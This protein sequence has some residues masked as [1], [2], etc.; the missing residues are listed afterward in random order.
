MSVLDDHDHVYGEKLR[1]AAGAVSD[2]Q[3]VVA[4]A[5]QLLTLGIPCLYYGTEQGLAG[6][7]ETERRWLPGWGSH[8]RYLREA[9]FGPRFPRIQGRNGVPGLGDDR[10]DHDLPG[11]G[12]FGTA[13]A[14]CFD[15]D[16]PLY[17]R[18]AA[19]TLIRADFPVL[20]SGR[21]YLRPASV[22]GEPFAP[23]E[24]GELIG[25]S[26]IL[27]D[28]EA[29]CVVNPNGLAA[30]GADLL[31]DAQLNPPGSALTVIM[32]SAQ[33]GGLAEVA[34]P[35][36]SQVPVRQAVSGAAYVEIR[37]VGPSEAMVLVNRP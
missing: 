33:A 17:L 16:H 15:P 28:E 32:N 23:A 18:T 14:H 34:H 26:R 7:E 6:P 27:T 12:P 31:I 13:G 5:L 11:F 3:S 2:H 29:L 9:M 10:L 8:D 30:R 36:G 25:W 35:V 19:I 1:F 21:Q 4:T 22:F 24:A 20:R 37:D